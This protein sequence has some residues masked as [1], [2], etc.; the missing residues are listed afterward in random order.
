VRN[1]RFQLTVRHAS[2]RDQKPIAIEAAEHLKRKHPHSA[3]VVK[4]LQS[5]EVTAVSY[6]PDL[7]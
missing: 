3:I 4:D 1:L 7:C 2:Y 6:K 5:G